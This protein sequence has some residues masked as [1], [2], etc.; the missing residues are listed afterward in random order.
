MARM[1][2]RA[3]TADAG[4]QAEGRTWISTPAGIRGRRGD[5]ERGEQKCSTAAGILPERVAGGFFDCVLTWGSAPNTSGTVN[6]LAV[7]FRNRTCDPVVKNSIR[8]AS[9]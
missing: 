1:C 4:R 2:L 6:T 8:I 9:L 5:R 3:C 7:E